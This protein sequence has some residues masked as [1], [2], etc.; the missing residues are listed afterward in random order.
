MTAPPGRRRF[1][2]LALLTLVVLAAG[3][4]D[5]DNPKDQAGDATTTSGAAPTTQTS[6]QP[7]AADEA[8]VR[9]VLLKAGDLP[10]AWA[11]SGQITPAEDDPGADQ[12]A[13][14]CFGLPLAE[15][16][17]MTADLES[18]TFTLGDAE[19]SSN[20]YT[21]PT[22]PIID[23]YQAALAKDGAR[24]LAR[25]FAEEFVKELPQGVT[26]GAP[27][28]RRA[29]AAVAGKGSKFIFAVTATEQASGAQIK[30]SGGYSFVNVD[31]LGI[32]TSLITTGA[33]PPLPAL[34]TATS[35]QYR[36][37]TG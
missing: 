1:G 35:A 33:S 21:A 18:P 25:L 27:E 5:A 24:C 34:D 26:A 12:L 9:A 15:L 7:N 17:K 37:A 11:V 10:A 22:Q 16:D 29:G 32:E 20:A 19:I 3:C 36:R 6:A 8:R 28:V 23:Q 2:R 13:A 14:E 31:R 30:I 4:D